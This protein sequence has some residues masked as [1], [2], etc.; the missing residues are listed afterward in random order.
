VDPKVVLIIDTDLGF[1]FW[2]GR[3]L[4]DA[5]HQVLPA[6]GL[7]EAS[8][9]LH[10]LNTE[11]H[12]L[13]VNPSLPGAADFAKGLRRSWPNAKLLVALSDNDPQGGQIQAADIIVRKPLQPDTAAAALWLKMVEQ[14]LDRSR[15]R[16]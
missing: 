15:T 4:G 7:S 13:I 9:L 10:E 11:V 8:S 14:V 2:L 1:V 12:L 5:G 3:V 6:K 16:E